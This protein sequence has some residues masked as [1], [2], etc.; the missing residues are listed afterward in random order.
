MA[1]I[2]ET[3]YGT[4]SSKSVSGYGDNSLH[5]EVTWNGAQ[6]T[7]PSQPYWGAAFGMEGITIKLNEGRQGPSYPFVNLY[8]LFDP[9]KKYKITITE[10][11]V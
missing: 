7:T 4:I 9:N 10:E 1:V 8:D 11:D 2:I 6:T 5:T 3:G